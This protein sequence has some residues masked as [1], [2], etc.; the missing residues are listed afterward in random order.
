MPM[1]RRPKS[2]ARTTWAGA[3]GMTREQADAGAVDAEQLPG[4]LP[5]LL[6]GQIE[7][8]AI[9]HR[10]AQPGVIEHLTLELAGFPAGITERNE[11]V[12]GSFAARNRG[13]HVARGRHL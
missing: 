6:K 7:D 13:Q 2:K 1:R 5:A 9:I 8:D 3:S 10:Q 11:S 12:L 4:R